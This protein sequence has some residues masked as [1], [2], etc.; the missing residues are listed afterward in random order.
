MAA[1]RKSE[2][3][4]C[5]GSCRVGA[6]ER[7]ETEL[8]LSEGYSGLPVV[9]PISIWRARN[10][11]PTVF[12]TAAVHGDELNGTGIIRALLQESPFTLVAGSLILVPVVNIFGLE[13]HQRYLPDRRDLNRCFPGDPAGSLARR[14]A[15]GIFQSVITKCDFGIDLH[16][17][18]VRRT[19]F[20]NVRADLGDP[21]VKQL[22]EAFGSEVIINGQ[23]PRGSLRRAAT[24]AGCPTII[25]EAGEVWK[26]EPS[27][28]EFGVRGIRNVLIELGMVDGSPYKPPYQ[29]SVKKTKW[30]RAE[31]GGL[32]GFHVAPGDVVEAGE[33]LATQSNLLGGELE[34]IVSPASGIVI[35]ITTLPAIKPGDPVCHLALPKKGVADIRR[36]LDRAPDEGIHE[37]LREDLSTS[38]A[39]TESQ[40][41]DDDD[42]AES[43]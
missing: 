25:L 5:V 13:R 40:E 1:N 34:E 42:A 16:T 9:I 11:G 10:A 33:P 8:T 12:V 41:H 19:N 35:G 36:A 27:V 20:P 17:A 24:T 22:A 23:G 15:H 29:I 6:G 21:K 28:V 37:R 26:I 43:S 7:C 4:L 39:V 3:T 31:K 2:N 38:V 18:A 30:I 32:L 14:F